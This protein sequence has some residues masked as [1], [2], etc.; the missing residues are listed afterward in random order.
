MAEDFDHA[1]DVVD[2]DAETAIVKGSKEPAELP[3][4]RSI[5]LQRGFRH[6]LLAG[7]CSRRGP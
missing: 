5:P 6:R 2:P 7:A 3:L 4:D 1:I